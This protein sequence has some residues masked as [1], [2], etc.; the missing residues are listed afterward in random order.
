MIRPIVPADESAVRSLQSN[1]SYADS[2]LIDA[3]I[4][5]PFVGRVAVH[6]GSV[7]GY[8]IALPGE[9]TTLSE[10][11][12]AADFRR[13]GYGRALVDAIAEVSGADRTVV[14][15]PAENEGAERFYRAIG[16]A[17]RERLPSFY[18]DGTDALRLVRGE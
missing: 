8:A 7:V 14:T 13:H 18:A 17:V 15:T 12:V 16:F 6:E 1:L 11:V 5:G 10:L 3:A 9:E 4:D 2:Q